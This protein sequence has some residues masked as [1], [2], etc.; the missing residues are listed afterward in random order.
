[1]QVWHPV[2]TF[3]DAFLFLGVLG[4]EVD[5]WVKTMLLLEVV[6]E[7]PPDE[8]D[9]V[10]GCIISHGGVTTTSGTARKRGKYLGRKD[11][12]IMLFHGHLKTADESESEIDRRMHG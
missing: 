4:P 9:K 12:I 5:R 7:S 10:V 8:D 1:L 6:E 11:D 3:F 2:L